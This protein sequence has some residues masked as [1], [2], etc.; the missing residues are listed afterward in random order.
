[1]D[2]LELLKADHDR[3]NLLLDQFRTETGRQQQILIFESV[4][5]DLNVHL[6]V[7]EEIFYPAFRNYPELKEIVDSFF[8][9]H[10]EV[11][12]YLERINALP[13]GSTEIEGQVTT[14]SDALNR[15]LQEEEITLFPMVRK[16]MKRSERERLG[17]H[18]QAMKTELNREAA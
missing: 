10:Q 5:N 17:R 12:D 4:R 18:I 1:M 9:E 7:E 2:V 11:R 14:F 16:V 13:D 3:I 8:K 6:K 15:H